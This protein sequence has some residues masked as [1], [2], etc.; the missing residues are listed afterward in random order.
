GSIVKS[1]LWVFAITIPVFLLV[2][3]TAIGV[4]GWQ[5]TVTAIFGGLLFGVGAGL[6]G[7]CA[8]ATMAR[9]VDGE[10]GMLLT[11]GGFVLGVLLFVALL[12]TG[13]LYRPEPAPS[14]LPD[15]MHF[16]P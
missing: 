1:S 10:I 8:Y 15:L 7:A 6:N 3:Q 11:I 12:G 4:S 9:M 2:P 16:A 14:A 13:T 5:L